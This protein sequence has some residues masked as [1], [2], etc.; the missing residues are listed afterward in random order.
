MQSVA[1]TC[2]SSASSQCDL[3]DDATCT[4][5]VAPPPV[6][7]LDWKTLVRLTSRQNKPL[8]LDTCPAPSSSSCRFCGS[9]NKPL[10]TWFWC[11]NQEIV[12]VILWTKSPN[13]SC[14]FWG[15][16]WETRQ[17]KFTSCSLLNV[18]KPIGLQTEVN[19]YVIKVNYVIGI[20]I[21]LN[22]L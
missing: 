6:L 20:V 2:L 15:P 16:N 10:P 11:T 19:L 7:R 14:R 18:I 3:H 22:Y 1:S 13:R 21:I 4:I 9:T 8:D 17:L 5:R 12:V